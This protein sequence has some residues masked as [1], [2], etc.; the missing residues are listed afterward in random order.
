M[1][2]EIIICKELSKAFIIIANQVLIFRIH[3]VIIINIR[4]ILTKIWVLSE[5]LMIKIY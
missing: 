3:I 2:G 1:Y 5:I 4:K